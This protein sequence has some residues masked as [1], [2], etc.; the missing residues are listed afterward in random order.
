MYI[1]FRGLHLF[2]A[3][4]LN[5]FH[6]RII[7]LTRIIQRDGLKINAM[8]LRSSGKKDPFIRNPFSKPAKC[9]ACRV[10]ITEALEFRVEIVRVKT[11]MHFRA[12]QDVHKD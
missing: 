8:G 10:N 6:P 1:S 11:K 7:R 3:G 2:E 12:M 4:Y 5:Y 9:T